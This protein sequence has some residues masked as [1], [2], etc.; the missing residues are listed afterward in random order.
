MAYDKKKPLSMSVLFPKD[1]GGSSDDEE[2]PDSSEDDMGVPPDF[3]AAYHD[4]R[5][6]PSA[7]TM[8][9]MIKSCVEGM[10]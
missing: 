8:W 1:E 3:E 4:Y 2:S 9:E 7:E 10:K 5:D 6:S